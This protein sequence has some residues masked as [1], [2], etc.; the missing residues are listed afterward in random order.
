MLQDVHS[1]KVSLPVV[2][3]VGTTVLIAAVPNAWIYVHDFEG[4]FTGAGTIDI[5]SGTT[6]LASF[7]LTGGEVIDKQDEPGEDNRPRFE[8]K[9]GDTFNVVVGG[10][11]FTG[12]L[13][14]SLRF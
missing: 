2:A 6:V 8:C 14:Y 13:H 9:P 5:R 1:R 11:T 10:G 7:S 4:S 3:P 12:A